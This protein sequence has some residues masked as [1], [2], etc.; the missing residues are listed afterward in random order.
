M[1]LTFA[2]RA[3]FTSPELRRLH[4]ASFGGGDSAG[5]IDWWARVNAHSLGW[6]V[7]RDGAALAG[8]VNVAW[9]GGEHAFVLDTMVAEPY[10]RTG[11]GTRLVA[12]AAEGARATGCRWL[13][14]DFE[15]HLTKFYLESCGFSPTPAGLVSLA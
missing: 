4:V 6:V 7:A 2:W 11:A 13:H 15:P 9:D 3:P 10:R 8:F 14:V 12:L 5:P 1:T